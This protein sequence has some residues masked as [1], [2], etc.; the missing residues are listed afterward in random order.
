M[1]RQ[2]HRR[3]RGS[4]EHGRARRRV[5][6]PQAQRALVG[7]ARGHARV[8]KHR[9][10]PT[11]EARGAPA[12]HG[13]DA[14]RSRER[15][16][17][18]ATAQARPRSI[19]RAERA[20]SRGPATIEPKEH[21]AVRVASA[22]GERVAAFAPATI[23]VTARRAAAYWQQRRARG[24]GGLRSSRRDGQLRSIA[25]AAVASRTASSGRTSP[26]P[27]ADHDRQRAAALS[28]PAHG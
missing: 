11:A 14:P 24:V 21:A 5:A 13:T 6:Q 1:A 18:Q 17:Q 10:R 12:Q 26:H 28:G 2:H 27:V 4:D 25:R 3:G 8:G 16:A 23:V 9:A 15:R 22:D 19:R 20:R 7:V